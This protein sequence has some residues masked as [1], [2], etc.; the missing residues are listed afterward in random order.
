MREAEYVLTDP[1][2]IAATYLRNTLRNEPKRGRPRALT[3]AALVGFWFTV[4][5]YGPTCPGN[6]GIDGNYGNVYSVT[7]EAAKC[8]SASIPTSRPSRALRVRRTGAGRKR[9]RRK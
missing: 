5:Q 9:K 3:A 4:G 6:P 1:L 2:G 8:G 7:Y